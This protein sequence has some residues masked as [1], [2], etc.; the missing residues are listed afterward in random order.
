MPAKDIK[1]SKIVDSTYNFGRAEQYIFLDADFSEW[2]RGKYLAKEIKNIS[3]LEIVQKY[4]LK[5]LVFGNYVTQEERFFFLFKIA[6][7][8]EALAKIAGKNNL[9]KNLLTIAFGSEG[10]GRAKAHFSPTKNLINLNRGRKSNYIDILKG[11]HSFIH[12]Y[13]HFI[14]CLQGQS[15]KTTIQNFASDAIKSENART[16]KFAQVTSIAQ[17]DEKYYSKLES[18]YLQKRIEIFAR[19][20]EATI[21]HHVHSKFPKYRKFFDRTYREAIY[22]PK[23]KIKSSGITPKILSIMKTI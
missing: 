2:L 14:D 13:G 17:N 21:T 22:Y 4:K 9:G 16:K 6:N 11:E 5:G 19:L 20:F 23:S 12:E 8:L 10:I 7:Q 15:D 1:I 3:P 18:E